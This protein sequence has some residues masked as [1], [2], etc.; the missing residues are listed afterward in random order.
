GGRRGAGLGRA[1]GRGLGRGVGGA[2]DKRAALRQALAATR[3][4]R[5]QGAGIGDDLPDLPLLRHVGLAVAVAD[6]CPEVR[7][8]AHYVTRAPGGGGAVREAVEWIL[9][10]QGAWQRVLDGYR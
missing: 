8:A 2:E 1:P 4:R 7:H 6:G 10:A 3:P 9:R 5:D